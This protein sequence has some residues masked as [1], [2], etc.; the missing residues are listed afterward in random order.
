MKPEKKY[1]L[2]NRYIAQRKVVVFNRFY[3]KQLSG[4]LLVVF[5][6][7]VYGNLHILVSNL[8]VYNCF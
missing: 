4:C 2:E 8:R 6:L 5:Q 3:A 7:K 1:Y